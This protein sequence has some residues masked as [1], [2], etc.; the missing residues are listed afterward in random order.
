MNFHNV[1]LEQFPHRHASMAGTTVPEVWF[2]DQL[3]GG[4]TE[5]K[6]LDDDGKLDQMVVECLTTPAG[7]YSP[8]P[9]DPLA[10]KIRENIAQWDQHF[11]SFVSESLSATGEAVRRRRTV[12]NDV[13]HYLLANNADLEAT[14]NSG[15]EPFDDTSKEEWLE[16]VRPKL[17]ESAERP[18][19]WKDQIWA[20]LVLKKQ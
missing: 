8:L 20:T 3:I 19:G 12:Q 2:N 14:S 5:C 17:I 4:W 10:K 16:K 18:Q 15:V 1:D 13:I 11:S 6:K 7:Q 9:V